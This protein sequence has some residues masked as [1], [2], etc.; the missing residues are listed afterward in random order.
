MVATHKPFSLSTSLMTLALLNLHAC[1]VTLP[2]NQDETLPVSFDSTVSFTYFSHLC[3]RLAR[4][5]IF[6]L[7]DSILIGKVI[8]IKIIF[9]GLVNVLKNWFQ[10]SRPVALVLW[11]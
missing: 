7:V 5:N 3:L 1:P 4:V 10:Y 9:L 8:E 6:T 2:A 11:R